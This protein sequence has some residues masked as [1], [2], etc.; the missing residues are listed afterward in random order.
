MFISITVKVCLIKGIL[1][2]KFSSLYGK[3]RQLLKNSSNDSSIID[4]Y[5]FRF[6]IFFIIATY[7]GILF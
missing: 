2:T 3:L 7:L 5:Y 1:T 4:F 6:I